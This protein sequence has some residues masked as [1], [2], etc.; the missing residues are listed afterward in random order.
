M[1]G[2]LA[3]VREGCNVKDLHHNQPTCIGGVCVER[4]RRERRIDVLPFDRSKIPSG[5][6]K[7]IQSG[8]VVLFVDSKV[9]RHAMEA[10]GQGERNDGMVLDTLPNMVRSAHEEQIVRDAAWG[11]LMKLASTSDAIHR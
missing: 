7:A 6:V 4:Y 2:Y 1:R 10:L 9:R 8:D 5:L 11:S 3:G